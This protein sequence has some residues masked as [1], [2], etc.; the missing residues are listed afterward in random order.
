[1]NRTDR[2][3]LYMLTAKELL[4]YQYYGSETEHQLDF[5]FIIFR[6]TWLH[7]TVPINDH[8]ICEWNVTV[9]TENFQRMV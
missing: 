7:R 4:I 5:S 9:Y 6:Y 1:M 3:A 2:N 8:K